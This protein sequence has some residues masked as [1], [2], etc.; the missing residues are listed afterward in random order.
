MVASDGPHG[1]LA[2]RIRRVGGEPSV[3]K[4]HGF[5]RVTDSYGGSGGFDQVPIYV[6]VRGCARHIRL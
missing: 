6:R 1:G 4:S 2:G 3:G 5:M